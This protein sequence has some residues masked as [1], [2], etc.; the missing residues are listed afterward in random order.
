MSSDKELLKIP[1]RCLRNEILRANDAGRACVADINCHDTGHHLT[2]AKRV[3]N[4]LDDVASNVCQALSILIAASQD[5][6]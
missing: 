6:V 2:Q 1:L 3:Q 4:A 5:T